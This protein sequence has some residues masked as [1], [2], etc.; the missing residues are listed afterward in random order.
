M[1]GRFIARWVATDRAGRVFVLHDEAPPHVN[2]EQLRAC[3]STL[4]T[5]L[6]A[7]TDG[8]WDREMNDIWFGLRE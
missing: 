3:G 8:Y 2:D 1:S 7:R 6:Y 5:P 4:R